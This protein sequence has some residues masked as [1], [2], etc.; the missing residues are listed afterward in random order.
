MAR[1]WTVRYETQ[2]DGKIFTIKTVP[3]DS[4]DEAEWLLAAL[5]DGSEVEKD[6]WNQVFTVTLPQGKLWLVLAGNE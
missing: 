2:S 5:P 4:R 1:K 3:C 6:I